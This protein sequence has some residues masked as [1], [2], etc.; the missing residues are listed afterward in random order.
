M[1]RT[2]IRP[3][4]IV[5]LGQKIAFGAGSLANQLFPAAVGAYMGIVVIIFGMD[6]YLAGILS[7]IP[8]FLD[9]VIDPI[10][11]YISDNTRSRW[12][13]RK[14]YIFIGS[15]ISGIMFIFMWQIFIEHSHSFNFYYILI[16]SIIFYIGLTIFAAPLI[17]LGYEMTPDYNERTRLMAV[18]QFLGQFAWMIS[19]WFLYIIYNFYGKEP[20]V[21]A[22]GSRHLAIYI[23]FLCLVLGVLPALMCKEINQTNIT[24][25]TKLSFK[26]LAENMKK[27]FK[28]FGETVKNGPFLRLCGATFCVFN[29]FQVIASYSVFIIMYY[30]FPGQKVQD[31]STFWIGLFGTISS[32]ATAFLVIPIITLI[33]SKI[34]K[35]NAFIIST[36]ISIIGYILKWWTFQYAIETHWLMFIPLPLI[37]FGIGG[38]FTLMMSMTADVCDYDELKNGMPRKEATFGAIYWW[39]VKLGTSLAVL[40]SGIVLSGVGFDP[41]LPTQNIDTL[42]KLRMADIIIPVISGL[43]AILLMWNYDIS[44]KRANEIRKIL[45][46]RRGEL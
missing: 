13:R 28:G 37:S 30:V 26:N 3:Q 32:L 1:E 16:I 15:I 11:G 12:G 40:F 29:G 22:Q 14:P 19:P 38:L 23:G 41:S 10:M 46:D 20:Q 39:M 27:F 9:A 7:A 5:P 43:I 6:P 24:G 31:V 8:R 25:Q 21:A 35:R 33:S 2:K 4:D 42:T 17:G 34:G 36:V 45:V 18:S 44:E